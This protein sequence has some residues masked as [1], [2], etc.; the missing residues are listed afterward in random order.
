MRSFSRLHN[1][2]FVILFVFG[3]TCFPQVVGCTLYTV[4]NPPAGT[5]TVTISVPWFSV[6]SRKGSDYWLTIDPVSVQPWFNPHGGNL[7]MAATV[8][9]GAV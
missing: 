1:Q 8:V 5:Y 7:A 2:L 4:T 3:S 9:Q 6:W